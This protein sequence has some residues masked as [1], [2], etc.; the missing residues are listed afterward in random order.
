MSNSAAVTSLYWREAMMNKDEFGEYN[1]GFQDA[2]RNRRYDDGSINTQ[3]YLIVFRLT[4]R[5][6]AAFYAA[7]YQDG[8]AYSGDTEI[9][10]PILAPR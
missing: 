10:L 6:W 2:V 4:F 7:G 8:L 1:R 9:W 3:D 5:R